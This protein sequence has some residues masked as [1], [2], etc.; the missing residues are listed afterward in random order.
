[1]NVNEFKPTD[2]T[3]ADNNDLLFRSSHTGPQ[4]AR[5]ELLKEKHH[6][7]A[8]V[9]KA[10]KYLRDNFDVVSIRIIAES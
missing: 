9:I 6:T 1:M 8:D 2:S 10:E 5:F 3:G 7:D 4:G